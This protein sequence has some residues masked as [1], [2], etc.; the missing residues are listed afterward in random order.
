MTMWIVGIGLIMLGFILECLGL[1][2]IF[3]KKDDD[4][5]G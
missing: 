3:E 1:S 2:G 4:G 5:N